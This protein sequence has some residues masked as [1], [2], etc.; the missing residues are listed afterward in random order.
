MN[1]FELGRRKRLRELLTTAYRG[2]P[3]ADGL[4]EAA[5]W[6]KERERRQRG[7]WLRWKHDAAFNPK[8]R[9]ST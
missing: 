4:S 3:T 2:E 5:A 6:R 7:A 9:S 1:E 8:L